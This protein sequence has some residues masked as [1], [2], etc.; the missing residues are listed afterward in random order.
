MSA[1]LQPLEARLEPMTVER[2]DAVVAVERSAYT[3]PWT[4]GQFHRFAGRR[5]PLP[6][7]A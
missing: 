3:H 1:V 5:L 7:R 6:V 4:R 2:V